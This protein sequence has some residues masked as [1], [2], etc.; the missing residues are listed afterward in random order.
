M[1]VLIV[2]RTEA[3][4]RNRSVDRRRG[5]ELQN[6]AGDTAKQ[7]VADYTEKPVVPEQLVVVA[8]LVVLGLRFV[9]GVPVAFVRIE[10][11]EGIAAAVDRN[12]DFA[13][14]GRDTEL[15]QLLPEPR[16]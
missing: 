16:D 13:D 15:D 1:A 9:P 11:F 12:K 14:T 7:R 8:P 5:K 10:T 4:H 2:V 3:E 6:I